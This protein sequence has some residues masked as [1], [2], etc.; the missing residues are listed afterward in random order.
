M[1]SEK[2]ILEKKLQDNE[3]NGNR[4]Y[5]PAAMKELMEKAGYSV[6]IEPGESKYLLS[7]K[8]NDCI[9]Y[10]NGEAGVLCV[11]KTVKKKHWKEVAE[12]NDEDITESYSC[13]TNEVICRKI[14]QN[15]VEDVRRITETLGRLR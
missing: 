14:L 6:D 9:F 15:P 13:S 8:K 10:I 11:K 7:G 1:E 5:D 12:W 4:T 3:D 2:E